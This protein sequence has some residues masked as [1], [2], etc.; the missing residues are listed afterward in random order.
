MFGAATVGVAMLWL[1]CTGTAAYL[2]MFL[3]GL[4]IGAESDVM[5]FLI[6]RYF[7]MRSM[8]ELFGCAF[9]S[10]TL[11][12][13]TGRYLIARGFDATG[14]YR[15]PMKVATFALLLA[16]LATFLLRRYSPPTENN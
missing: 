11:G 12:N 5:P 3:V 10:Y 9:G 7:G 6:S 14:S 8:G 4:A 2:A 1:G 16:T 13:A 15:L